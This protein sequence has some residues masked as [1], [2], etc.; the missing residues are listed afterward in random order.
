MFAKHYFQMFQ[1][2]LVWEIKCE[3]QILSLP[4]PISVFLPFLDI[5]SARSQNPPT[6]SEEVSRRGRKTQ[7]P[8]MHF[9]VF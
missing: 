4:S 1:T 3:R 5:L 7:R 8:P 2:C 9:Y 6:A